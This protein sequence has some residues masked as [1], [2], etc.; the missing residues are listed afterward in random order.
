MFPHEQVGRAVRSH[1]TPQHNSLSHRNTFCPPLPPPPVH[2]L[3]WLCCRWCSLLVETRPT[4]KL[5]LPGL[6]ICYTLRESTDFKRYLV[7]WEHWTETSERLHV[8]VSCSLSFCRWWKDGGNF[9][10]LEVVAGPVH[11]TGTEPEEDGPLD[12]LPVPP[13]TLGWTHRKGRVAA[14]RKALG[15]NQLESREKTV[16]A[17]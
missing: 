14:S 3:P 6:T 10:P 5:L 7:I 4:L 13:V 2:K 15:R 16:A 11:P 9:P 17:L 8:V 1:F 12:P